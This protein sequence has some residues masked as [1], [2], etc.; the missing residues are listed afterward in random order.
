MYVNEV[1]EML[2][3]NTLQYNTTTNTTQQTKNWS[4]NK[5]F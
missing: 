4:L 2:T 5:T 3:S 1:E